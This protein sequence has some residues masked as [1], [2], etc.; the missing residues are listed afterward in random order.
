MEKIVK[1]QS[2]QAEPL[3]DLNNNGVI[4]RNTSPLSNLDSGFNVNKQFQCQ[5]QQ[6]ELLDKDINNLI[7][8]SIKTNN[9]KEKLSCAEVKFLVFDSKFLLIILLL[10]S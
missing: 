2:Q 8:K 5:S 4:D 10:V 1:S 7:I 6:T 9:N 3:L